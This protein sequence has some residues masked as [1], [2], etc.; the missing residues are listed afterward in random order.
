[1]RSF[2][3]SALFRPKPSLDW[4]FRAGVLPKGLTYAQAGGLTYF[5][6]TGVLQTAGANVPAFDYDITTRAALGLSLW[7][8]ATNRALW[9]RDLTNVVWVKTA[10]TAT[11]DQTGID[12]AGNSA[13]RLTATAGNALVL[14]AVVLGSS[15]RAQSAYVKRI[16]G[17]GTVEMTTN[18][19][20][21]WTPVTVT[22]VWTQVRCPLQTVTNPILGFRIVTSGDEIAVDYVQNETTRF[23]PTILNTTAQVTRATHTDNSTAN[24][25][26]FNPLEGTFCAESI[27]MDFAAIYRCCGV[28]DGTVNNLV[29]VDIPTAAAGR[30]TVTDATVAQTA[31][32]AGTVV[33]GVMS[34]I[35]ASYKVNYFNIATNALLSSG[36]DTSGTVPV[37]LNT[38]KL[39]MTGAGVGSFSGWIQRIRYWP[40]ALSD[41]MLQTLSL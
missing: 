4:D 10:M 32:F 26:F 3:N 36:P 16:T 19:G 29:Q 14:Q 20:T 13:T 30:L 34:K 23:T 22:S 39:G 41:Q 40:K 38:L 8:A 37:G 17:S 24:L 6:A 15:V 2:A 7:L 28:S 5:N 9:N 18:N 21:T 25:S 35:A 1:M 11:Q 31:V 27:L 33:A 12:G